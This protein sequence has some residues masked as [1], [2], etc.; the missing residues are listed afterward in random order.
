MTY[1]I[2]A[3]SQ[4]QYSFRMPLLGEINWPIVNFM[5]PSKYSP[6]SS[7]FSC[8]PGAE[9]TIHIS[10]K[11]LSLT[12]QFAA[13]VLLTFI[14]WGGLWRSGQQNEQRPDHV[15]DQR[16]HRSATANGLICI[17]RDSHD[18]FIAKTAQTITKNSTIKWLFAWF[19]GRWVCVGVPISPLDAM[20]SVN[21]WPIHDN[22]WM[23]VPF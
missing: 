6:A 11:S 22:L 2:T 15:R 13:S 7:A 3:S 12:I 14:Q 10:L 19:Y 1:G 5:S 17:L 8:R 18:T 9:I 21:S 23:N 4:R 16:V 20:F